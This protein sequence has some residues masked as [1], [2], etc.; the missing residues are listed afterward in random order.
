[1]T[2]VSVS[3]SLDRLG[4]RIAAG[5]AGRGKQDHVIDLEKSAIVAGD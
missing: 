3:A 4:G 1:M 5:V 2:Q